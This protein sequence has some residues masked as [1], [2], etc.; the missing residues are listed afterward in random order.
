MIIMKG[1]KS[2][3]MDFGNPTNGGIPGPSWREAYEAVGSQAVAKIEFRVMP[4]DEELAQ[5]ELAL[6]MPSGPKLLEL[7]KKNPPFPGWFDDE[8]DAPF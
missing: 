7:A 8:E 1:V 6:L 4:I 2:V 5:K 3:I